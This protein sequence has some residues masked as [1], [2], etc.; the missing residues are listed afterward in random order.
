MQSEA[1]SNARDLSR[2]DAPRYWQDETSGVLA[3]SMRRYLQGDELTVRDISNLRAYF[4]QWIDS[5]VWDENPHAGEESKRELALLRSD[6]K[7]IANRVCLAAWLLRAE[8]L[9]M[10]PL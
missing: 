5:P 3:E 8:E 10:D 6:A 7:I 1:K 2:D 4:R 9:G